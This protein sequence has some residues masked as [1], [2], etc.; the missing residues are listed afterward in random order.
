MAALGLLTCTARNRMTGY[1]YYRLGAGLSTLDPALVV[2][3]PGGQLAAKLF[4]GLVR[5]GEGL[6]A[7]PDIASAWSISKDGLTYTFKLKKGVRFSNGKEV[8]AGDFKYSFERVLNPKVKS[9]NTW[10]FDK[11]AGA[12]EFMR[13]EARGLRGVSVLDDYTLEIRLSGPFLPFLGLLSMPPAYVVPEEEVKKWGPDFSSHPTGTGPFVMAKWL[14]GRHLRFDAR[15][16]YFDKPA[17]VKGIFYRIIPE[18]MTAVMEFE[19]GNLDVLSIPAS[20]YSRYGSSPKWS[21]LIDSIE[22]INT[23]YLGLNCSRPPFDDPELR[24]AVNYAVDSKKMLESL[25]EGRGRLASGPVPDMLRG[26]P[27]PERY[28]YD[29][30]RAKKIIARRRLPEVNFFITAD[31]QVV[32]IAEV[33]QAYLKEVGLRV[34]L[35]QLEWSAFKE[36][37]NKGEADMFWLSWWADYPDPENFLFPLFHS[38]N[39]GPSGNRVRYTNPKVDALIEAGQHALSKEEAGRFYE[40]A[41]R[42]IVSDAPWVFFWHR[43]DYTLR[44]PWVKNHK[45]HPVYSMDKGTDIS[46]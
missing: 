15:A 1:V 45:L 7:E 38:S 44:Q 3:V 12:R 27:A 25:H 4:N 9:P 42:I 6:R 34:K 41:E 19:V 39:H 13:G 20:E 16:D 37:V 8:T 23:Y 10:I 18:E 24:R 21:G 28:R 36:A 29:P 40:K 35:R 26:W 43:R 22:G 14:P 5:L 17:R 32:D 46:L 31:P 30:E 2:D 33:I 11:V